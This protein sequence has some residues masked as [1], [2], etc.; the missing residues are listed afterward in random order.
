MLLPS[1]GLIQ[2][3]A[4]LLG[5]LKGAVLLHDLITSAPFCLNPYLVT[6]M[7]ASWLPHPGESRRIVIGICFLF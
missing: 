1:F 2:R 7:F 6:D 5:R 4:H 3:N